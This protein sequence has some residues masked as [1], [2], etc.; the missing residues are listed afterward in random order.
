MGFNT[1]QEPFPASDDPL[2]GLDD[3][4]GPGKTEVE[5]SGWTPFDQEPE[6]PA[7]P[8]DPPPSNI[9]APSGWFGTPMEMVAEAFGMD[10]PWK[11]ADD[12][13]KAHRRKV[14]AKRARRNKLAKASRRRNR[15]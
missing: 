11:H 1:L 10:R 9:T 4:K 5:L 14:L 6:K 13:R 2:V 15:R 12:N 3:P 8:T 7:D